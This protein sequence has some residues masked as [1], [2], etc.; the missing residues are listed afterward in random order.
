MLQAIVIGHIGA[1]AVVKN[2]NGSEFTTFRVAHS[3]RFTD[4]EGH[5][6]ENTT[7]VDVTLPGKPAVGQYLVR[8]QCVAVIGNL[9]TRVYSSAYDRCYKAGV[10]I[11]A[12]SVELIGKAPNADDP[13]R[14]SDNAPEF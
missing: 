4:S 7:W 12:R 1:D 3:E 2:H 6:V 5:Q 9:S 13:D 11:A 14:S 8:G 10:R